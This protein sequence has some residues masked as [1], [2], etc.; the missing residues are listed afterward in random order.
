MTVNPTRKLIGTTAAVLLISFYSPFDIAGIQGSGLSSAA[1]MGPVSDSSG[2]GTV[3]VNGV[4]YDTSAATVLI[5]G[6]P[7]SEAQLRVGQIVT[8]NGS[9]NH[10]GTTGTATEVSF[11]GNVEGAA[12]QID[13]SANSFVVL[14]QTVRVTGSTL[15]DNAIQPGDLTGLRAGTLVEVSGFANAEGEIVA[16]RVDL[17]TPGATL[18]VSGTI[19]SLDTT[20]QTFQIN[21]LTINYAGSAVASTLRNGTSVEVQ[22]VALAQTGELLATRVEPAPGIEAAVGQFVDLT[23]I[24]TGVP[25]LLEFTLQ[26]QPIIIDLNTQLALHGIPLGLDVEVD[27]QGTMTGSGVVLAKK[28]EVRPQGA[29]LV[30]G[31]VESVSA[32]K[33]SGT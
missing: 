6:Q 2:P 29:S 3:S 21:A 7:G 33:A 13:P 25:S 4:A 18:L 23:G 24:I 17:K 22:G 16:S 11:S 10:D 30:R 27:V 20:A 9:V 26:G 14:G 15:Y 12:T 1:V 32:V 31:L 19:E 28:I 8:I 5:D